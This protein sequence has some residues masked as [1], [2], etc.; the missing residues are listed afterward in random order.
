MLSY[1]EGG[2]FKNMKVALVHDHLNQI[3]G[4]EKVLLVFKEIWPK[5]PIYTLLYYP[6]KT[7]GLFENFEIKESFIKKLPFSHKFFKFY[8]PL[9]PAAIEGLDLTDYDLIISDASAFAKGIIPKPSALHICYCHTPTRYLWSDTHSYVQ[10]LNYS[11]LLKRILLIILN[12]LRS[13]D[14]QAAQRVDKFIANSHF[15]AQRIKKYYHRSSKV[16][17]PPVETDKYKISSDIR[18]YFLIIARLRPYK[19]V[20]LAIKA[21]NRLRIPLK[22]IGKGEEEKKLRK[23]AKENIEFLGAVS[24]EEKVKYLSHCQALI[25]PQ[26]EDFGITAV[27]AMA[28]GRPVI[29]YKSGGALETIIEGKTGLFFEEQTWEDLANEVI[30]F[31][32]KDFN[33]YEIKEHAQ[34]FNPERFKKEIREFVVKSWQEHQNN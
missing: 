34:K 23:M 29:A 22:I 31:N 24:E 15:V 18:N 10:N 11:R 33:P 17:Y 13:W 27:E 20:D 3:G 32:S 7:R 8:L 12:R 6:Q 2:R 1:Q 30:K 5:A 4:A 19:K 28:S 21:F 26:E 9:M 25:Y 14:Y 16:I